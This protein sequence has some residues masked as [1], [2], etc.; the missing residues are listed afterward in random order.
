[1]VAPDFGTLEVLDMG[2]VGLGGPSLV[3]LVWVLRLCVAS[4]E[5]RVHIVLVLVDDLGIGDLSAYGGVVNTP[6]LEA[7]ARDGV[8]FEAGYT[9]SPVCAPSRCVLLTGRHAGH[10]SIRENTP[11]ASLGSA[12]VSLGLRLKGAG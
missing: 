5:E 9:G 1:M 7:W 11:D 6:T 4:R 8:T 3:A 2:P 10:A 12:D